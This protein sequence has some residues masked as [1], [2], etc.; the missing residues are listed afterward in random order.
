MGDGFKKYLTHWAER[1]GKSLDCDAIVVQE[2]LRLKILSDYCCTLIKCS[3]IH[4][5]TFMYMGHHTPKPPMKA[6]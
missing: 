5:L 3:D 1:V 6:F 4:T 2:S